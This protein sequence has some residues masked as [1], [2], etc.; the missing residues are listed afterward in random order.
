MTNLP[1]ST[2]PLTG[3]RAVLFDKDGTLFDFQA[4]WGVWAIDFLQREAAGDSALIAR[5]AEA[6]QYDLS[7]RRFG[8][9]SPVIAGTGR[10]VA[11]LIAPL[12]DRPVAHLESLIVQSSSEMTPVEAVPLAPLLQ[13]LRGADLILGIAT[14]DYESVA[15][16]H[17]GPHAAAFRTIYGFDSGHGGKP[18]PG[19]LLA[20]AR[21]CGLATDSILMVGDS[22]HDLAAGRAAGMPT[23][24]VL[25]GVAQAGEL[26][27]LADRIRPDIGHLPELL[28]LN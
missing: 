19:M 23:L 26:A 2:R 4:S 11:E 8:R 13:R 17:L 6:L 18:A 27:D 21:A 20:F 24:A 14:N 3:I 10:E 25:T 7:T 16:R 5:L 28:G 12:L 1:P 15:R 22:R 9:L